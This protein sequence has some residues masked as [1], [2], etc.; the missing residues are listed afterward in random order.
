MKVS[1][2]ERR[3]AKYK[4]EKK[5][6]SVVSP[7][8]SWLRFVRQYCARRPSVISPF[9]FFRVAYFALFPLYA[10]RYFVFFTVQNPRQKDGKKKLNS[11][12]AQTSHHIKD[13]ML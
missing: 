9:L 11:E 12:M 1:P 2:E 3:L 4:E 13:T 7:Y 8:N 10:W 6:I 5:E